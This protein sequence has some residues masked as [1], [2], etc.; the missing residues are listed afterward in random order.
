MWL[1]S[2]TNH[3]INVTL[4]VSITN[5]APLEYGAPD[6]TCSFPLAHRPAGPR[7]EVCSWTLLNNSVGKFGVLC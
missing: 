5:V 7:C 1:F 6:L 3:E 4:E 2:L